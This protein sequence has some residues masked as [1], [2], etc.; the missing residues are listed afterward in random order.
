MDKE[1][2]FVYIVKILNSQSCTEAG[3]WFMVPC[4]VLRK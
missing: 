1:E 4:N 3:K 2:E